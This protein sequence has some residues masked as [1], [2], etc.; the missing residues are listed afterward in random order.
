MSQPCCER[1]RRASPARRGLTV[2]NIAGYVVPTAVLAL[3]PKCPLCLAAYLAL[4]TGLG[5]TI[6]TAAHLR[7][8]L[9]VL[10][11]GCLIFL[12][13]KHAVRW[14]AVKRIS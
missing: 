7:T 8:L 4:G 10:S 9:L 6:S 12:A 1:P 13:T 3:L 14:M 5:I 2:T 11:V